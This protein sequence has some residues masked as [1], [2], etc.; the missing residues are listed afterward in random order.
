MREEIRAGFAIA[1]IGAGVV[2]FILLLAWTFVWRPQ[3]TKWRSKSQ[4]QAAPIEVPERI[5]WNGVEYDCVPRE[6]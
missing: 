1:I 2:V 4:H 3:V 5:I 6:E